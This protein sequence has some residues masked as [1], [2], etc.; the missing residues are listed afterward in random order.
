MSLI[1]PTT[2]RENLLSDNIHTWQESC[3]GKILTSEVTLRVHDPNITGMHPRLAVWVELARR[4]RVVHFRRLVR[5]VPVALLD[6]VS[7]DA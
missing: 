1:L 4:V 6:V 7:L 2:K 5:I 3:D